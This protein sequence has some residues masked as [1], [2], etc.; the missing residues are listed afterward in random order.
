MWILPC[1]LKSMNSL[2]MWQQSAQCRALY[3]Y[4]LSK[5]EKYLKENKV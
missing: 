2:N 1:V 3:F 4:N 5:Q